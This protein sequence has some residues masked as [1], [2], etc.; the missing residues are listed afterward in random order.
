MEKR[1]PHPEAQNLFLSM[2]LI[3]HMKLFLNFFSTFAFVTSSLSSP[4]DLSNHVSDHCRPCE[5][6]DCVDSDEQSK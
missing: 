6:V 1:V 5:V 4:L 3:K 2:Y